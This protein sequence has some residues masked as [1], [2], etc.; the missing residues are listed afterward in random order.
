[1]VRAGEWK[2]RLL[3]SSPGIALLCKCKE[4]VYMCL[5]STKGFTDFHGLLIDVREPQPWMGS[6]STLFFS[7]V[8][9]FGV[10]SF[11]DS[12]SDSLGDSGQAASLPRTMV[13]ASFKQGWHH[14]PTSASN[15]L[16]TQW[17]QRNLKSLGWKLSHGANHFRKAT[18]S[19]WITQRKWNLFS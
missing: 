10:G 18:T 16:N 7:M 12:A 11:P 17:G 3:G 19:C 2:T 14:L 4:A 9:P 6:E 5:L 8:L 13:P 15:W 1:M